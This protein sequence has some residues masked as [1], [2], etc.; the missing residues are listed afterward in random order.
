ML[1]YTLHGSDVRILCQEFQLLMALLSDQFV[2]Q[3]TFPQ[4]LNAH[5]S[6][7]RG[8]FCLGRLKVCANFCLT[9]AVKAR[10]AHDSPLSQA[11]Q[12]AHRNKGYELLRTVPW[13]LLPPVN[14]QVFFDCM[15]QPI[16]GESASGCS[17]LHTFQLPSP[18]CQPLGVIFRHPWRNKIKSP[19]AKV[20]S[21]ST[22]HLGNEV[23]SVNSQS[24]KQPL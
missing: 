20:L 23:K 12:P 1:R 14:P 6:P 9:D 13:A 3:L 22:C 19:R 7:P 18:C 4:T 21:S 5:S 2:A 15:H 16:H 8:Q 11:H 17:E 10:A 24:G